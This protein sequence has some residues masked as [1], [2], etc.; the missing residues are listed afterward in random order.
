MRTK[1]SSGAFTLTKRTIFWSLKN[2]INPSKKIYSAN[3]RFSCKWFQEKK[4]VT[5][6]KAL[7]PN[8]VLTLATICKILCQW[9]QYRLLFTQ[10][11][12]VYTYINNQQESLQ[13]Y[14]ENRLAA[15][16]RERWHTGMLNTQSLHLNITHPQ[17]NLNTHQN[18]SEHV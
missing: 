15:A 14:K 18:I 6:F 8:S 12:T 1:A 16:W 4:G 5:Y 9:R 11:L 2:D 17:L 3:F 7:S 10:R 13:A